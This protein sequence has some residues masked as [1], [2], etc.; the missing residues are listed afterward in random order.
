MKI[1]L[2]AICAYEIFEGLVI[3]SFYSLGDDINIVD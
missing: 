2:D 3:E 1:N